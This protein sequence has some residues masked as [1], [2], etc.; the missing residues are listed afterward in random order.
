MALEAP[1][2]A[3]SLAGET[4]IV[5]ARRVGALC[6]VLCLGL[7]GRALAA[8]AVVRPAR[9]HQR[10]TG[11]GASSAWTAPDLSDADADLLFSTDSGV[12]LSLL[13]VRIAPDGSCLELATAQKAQA[14]GAKVWATPWSPPA[15]WK[16][17]GDVNNGGSL[18]PAH[19]SDWAQSLVGFVTMMKAQGV[20]I[21]ALSAQNEP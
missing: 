19:A 4:P 14:R 13:R 7:P 20:D 3:D 5:R 1:P 16:S 21:T 9:T 18:L 6:L 12:G 2:R 11:F 10:I 17:N 15:A 8:D